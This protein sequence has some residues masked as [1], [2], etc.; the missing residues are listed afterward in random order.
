MGNI[1]QHTST[2]S[3]QNKNGEKTGNCLYD[4][5]QHSLEEE[6]NNSNAP[7]GDVSQHTF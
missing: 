3:N 2:N 1:S 6:K 7:M 5:S 4:L